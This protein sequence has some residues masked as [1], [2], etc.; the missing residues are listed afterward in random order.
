ME[1][2]VLAGGL[3]TRLRSVVKDAPKPMALINERPFLTYLFDYLQKY[4]VHKIILSIG[5]MH[6]VIEGYFGDNYKG[7]QIEYV[8]EETPLG[9]GGGL[10]IA[11]SKTT[12]ADVLVLNGDTLFMADIDDLTKTHLASDS[13]ITLAARKLYN[14][15]RYGTLT[16]EGSRVT[17]FEEKGY[18]ASGLVNGGV[19]ILRRQ[20]LADYLEPL[21]G[22]FSF[23]ADF[24]VPR[25]K[26]LR[27]FT[28]LSEAYFIDIGIPQDYNRAQEEFKTL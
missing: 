19:F 23:E 20:A 8:I 4:K 12:G 2:I 28:Y 5:Y 9:T 26:E 16:V 14:F 18:R 11:L 21:E 25:V 10:K 3:G 22:A 13:E 1:A 7:T 17:G 27:V 15:D 24:L 6:E